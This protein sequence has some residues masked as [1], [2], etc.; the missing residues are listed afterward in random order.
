MWIFCKHGF[1]SAVEN[2]HDRREVLVRARF[3]GD[4]EKLLERFV[5]HE[6][7]SEMEQLDGGGGNKA[8]FKVTSTPDADYAYRVSLP[9]RM[10]ADIVQNIAGEIDYQNFKDSVHEGGNS[11]RDAAYMGCW[12]QLRKG[13]M[14]Q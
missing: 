7:D 4:L 6:H 12:W 11:A 5:W 3:R 1:F 13:Q 2:W 10:W 8:R 14:N 9:K